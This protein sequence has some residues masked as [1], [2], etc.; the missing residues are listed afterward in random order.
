VAKQRFILNT[1]LGLVAPVSPKD[2]RSPAITEQSIM[3]V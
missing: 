1:F 2:E 3:K